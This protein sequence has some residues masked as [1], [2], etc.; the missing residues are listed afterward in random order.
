MSGWRDQL[1]GARMRV[2]QQ[3]NDRILNSQFSNQEWGLIMT[4]VEFDIE[5]PEDPETAQLVARTENIPQILPELENLPQG[6]GGAPGGGNSGSGGGLFSGL[7]GALGLGG[8]E[9]GVDQEKLDAAT[10]LVEEYTTE[11]QAYLEEEGRWEMIC[12]RATDG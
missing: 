10:N 12:E 9:E 8:G 11:L 4:A 1:A 6:M 7:F 3:F 5:K 2:D